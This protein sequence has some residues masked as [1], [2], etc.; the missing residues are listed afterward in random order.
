M[1]L[2]FGVGTPARVAGQKPELS[3]GATFD[4][5]VP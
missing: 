3:P 5:S 1:K 4:G 2:A